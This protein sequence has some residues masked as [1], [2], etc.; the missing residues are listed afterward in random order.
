VN[1]PQNAADLAGRILLS[2]IFLSSGLSKI[3]G[4]S[5][6]QAYMESQGVPGALLPLV[7]GVEVLVPLAVILGWHTRVAAFLLA[8]FSILSALLFHG[9]IGDPMQYI[10]FMKN[11][12][13]GGGFLILVARGPGEWSLDARTGRLAAPE[14]RLT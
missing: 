1:T 5:G 8:G 11:V 7:I 9:V 12:A 3:S 10:L 6:T 14:G 13:I 4:Y 2:A